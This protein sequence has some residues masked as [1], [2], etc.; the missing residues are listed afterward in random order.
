MV[1]EVMSRRDVA[2]LPV[3]P[4]GTGRGDPVSQIPAVVADLGPRQ[5]HSAVR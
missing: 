3:A 5:G 2:D 4:V 1:G